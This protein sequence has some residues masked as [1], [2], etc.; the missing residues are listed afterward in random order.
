MTI[1]EL[2]SQLQHIQAAN[3]SDTMEIVVDNDDPDQYLPI[4]RVCVTE[5]G[6][7]DYYPAE[8][9]K[10]VRSVVCIDLF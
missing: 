2:I 5:C 8:A 7:D 10:D 9:G 3:N 6:A 1:S 4:R